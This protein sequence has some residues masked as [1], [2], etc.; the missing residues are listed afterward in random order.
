[1]SAEIYTLQ[2]DTQRLR[3]VPELG[4]AVA[5]WDWKTAGGWTPLFRPWD[6]AKADMYTVACFPLTPWSN[7]ITGGGFEQDGVFHPI[8]LNREGENYPIHGDGWLQPWRV[9]DR[10]AGHI[11]LGLESHRFDG[12]P[13]DHASSQTFTFLP[14]GLAIDLTVTH[15]GKQPL[16]YGLGLHPYFVRNADTLL[17]ARSTGVW[18][19]GKDPIPIAYA[20]E[21]PPT[22]DYNH[23]AP[24]NGPMIDNCF[25]GW[26]GQAVITYPDR[27]LSVTM[28]MEDS[29]GYSLM[30]R[31]P[32]LPYFCYEPIT[33]PIDAFHMEGWPGLKVLAEG[34]SMS[35]KVR[36]TVAVIGNSSAG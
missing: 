19:S 20:T 35:L 15:L 36:I 10:S 30:Y 29:P 2:S 23:P 16:P 13:Y 9:A 22:W 25:N 3:L 12:N 34:E 27:G 5:G 1:M 32:D 31:P 18:L 7:R 26:D 14:D 28:T 6:G 33:Q 21:F 4:G 8:K 11:R 17:Q 24:L